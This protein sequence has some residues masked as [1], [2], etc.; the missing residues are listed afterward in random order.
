MF[1]ITANI[2]NGNEFLHWRI[3]FSTQADTDFIIDPWQFLQFMICTHLLANSSAQQDQHPSED[4]DP[5]CTDSNH[6]NKPNIDVWPAWPNLHS[7]YPVFCWMMT[8]C[9]VLKKKKRE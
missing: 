5:R 8:L 6:P 1:G 3:Q 9:L 2:N 7:C 4:G